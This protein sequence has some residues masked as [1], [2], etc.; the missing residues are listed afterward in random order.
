MT[1]Q[2]S[3]LASRYRNVSSFL[4]GAKESEDSLLSEESGAL[5]EI[6]LRVFFILPIGT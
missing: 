1:D 5:D 6:C 3:V 2:E 4:S